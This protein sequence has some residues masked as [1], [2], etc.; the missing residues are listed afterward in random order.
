MQSL[1]FTFTFTAPQD[2]AN[3][4][5]QMAQD[6]G[7][8]GVRLQLTESLAQVASIQVAATAHSPGDICV[9]EEASPD[10]NHYSV[11]TRDSEGLCTHVQDF[12][13]DREVPKD[14]PLARLGALALAA[15]LSMRHEAPIEPLELV[16]L[17]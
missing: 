4:V 11:Y 10:A 7:A 6:M 16:V 2:K 1:K 5:R 9:V 12:P 15:T 17:N 3:L 14:Q 8:K 13:F